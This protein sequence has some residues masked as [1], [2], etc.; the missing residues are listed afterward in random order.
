MTSFTWLTADRTV[1]R[2]VFGDGTLTVTAN[3]GATAHDGL[4][5]GCVD[6]T[7]KGG[8]PRRL[9]PAKVVS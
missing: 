4:P 8:E 7:L 2:T 1:Q 3:F 9:C 5:G 6:A